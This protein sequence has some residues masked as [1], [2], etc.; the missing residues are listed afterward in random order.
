M[1]SFVAAAVDADWQDVVRRAEE[2]PAGAAALFPRG[3]R[4]LPR[5][6]LRLLLAV[7][8]VLLL[9]FVGAAFT[10]GL[11]LPV[12]DFGQA[13]KAPPG[14]RVV[15]NFAVLDQGAPPGM[16]TDVIP[17]ETR[18][19][20]TFGEETLWVAPTKQGGFCTD[21]GGEGG[22]DRLGTVPLNVSWA[23]ERSGGGG[24]GPESERSFGG[25]PVVD[26]LSGYVNARWA[27]ALEIRFE[28]G[29][30]I[31]PRVVWVSKPIAA[32]FF[33]QTI[34]KAHRRAGHL[35][36]AVVALDQKGTFVSQDSLDPRRD[37]LADALMDK[38]RVAWE[39]KTTHG[40]AKT[41]TAPTRYEGTCYWTEFEARRALAG[42]GPKG[43]SF[44]GFSIAPL[45]TTDDVL[46]TGT[47]F[48]Q[49]ATVVFRYQD[50]DVANVSPHNGLILY[51][52]PSPHFEAGH[53]L[54]TIEGVDAQGKAVVTIDQDKVGPCYEPVPEPVPAPGCG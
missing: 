38:R 9:L 28:D 3:R 23:I 19:V 16:A 48:S 22:C 42:C 53:T 10:F 33:V 41:W 31:R 39:I 37:R 7:V 26:E 18:K 36:S 43:Y 49:I 45:R 14:S 8:A 27:T 25:V 15:K 1:R 29:D 40:P 51:E 11:G 50:G 54:A 6:R 46:F 30:V 24:S 12:L 35:I 2:A 5:R 20:A 32:G 21:L 13:D 44:D 17:N 34:S 4:L 47:T 52:V